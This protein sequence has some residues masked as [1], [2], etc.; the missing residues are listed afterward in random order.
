MGSLELFS[1]YLLLKSTDTGQTM[2]TFII[3]HLLWCSHPSQQKKELG[4]KHQISAKL[5][6]K[7]KK[8]L[9]VSVS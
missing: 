8:T 2:G 3:W 4:N 1:L 9:F 6:T 7:N 5:K